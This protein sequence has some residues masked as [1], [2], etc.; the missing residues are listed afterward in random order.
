MYDE[1]WDD[2]T[3]CKGLESES[4]LLQAPESIRAA[5]IILLCSILG[6]DE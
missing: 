4:T 1:E 2:L 5:M 3:T 6:L